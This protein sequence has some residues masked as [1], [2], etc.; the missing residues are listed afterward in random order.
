MEERLKTVEDNLGEARAHIFDHEENLKRL[1]E[2]VKTQE[3]II[4]NSLPSSPSYSDMD[5]G[6]SWHTECSS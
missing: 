5:Y 4:T 3:V 1:S 6:V 2:S